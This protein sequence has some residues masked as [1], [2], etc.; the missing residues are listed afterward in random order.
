MTTYIVEYVITDDPMNDMLTGTG[1]RRYEDAPD[2]TLAADQAVHFEA[3]K[4][5]R[6]IDVLRTFVAV[7]A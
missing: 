2:A 5:G 1:K 3:A 4:R 6:T 7:Q